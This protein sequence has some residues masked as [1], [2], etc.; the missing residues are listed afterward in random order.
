MKKLNL[1]LLI[2]SVI[3]L[4][5]TVLFWMEI[6]SRKQ[7]IRNQKLTNIESVCYEK[8]LFYVELIDA[9][10]YE[11]GLTKEEF[12]SFFRYNS[13]SYLQKV[14]CNDL[15]FISVLKYTNAVDTIKYDEVL[16][17]KSISIFFLFKDNKF[18]KSVNGC[19]INP[20]YI[21]IYFKSNGEYDADD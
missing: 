5:I 19:K 8:L 14:D 17:L 21:N 16:Q 1:I 13:V 7:L 3:I 4:F 6:N 11:Q 2:S 10:A 20:N 12:E 15:E 18:C 9:F